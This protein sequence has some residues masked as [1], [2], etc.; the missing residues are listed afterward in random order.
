MASLTLETVTKTFGATRAVDGVSLEVAAGEFVALLGPS[1][2]GKSTLLRLLAGFERA[3]AGVIRLGGRTM[4]GG[5]IHV[6][7]ERRSLGMVFQSYALWPHMTVARNVGYALRVQKVPAAERR[8]RVAAALETV[9][10]ANLAERRP[11]ALSGGQRQRVALARCLVK[12]PAIMLLDEPLANLDVHLRESMQTEFRR[13]HRETGATMVYVTHDQAEAMALAD[14]VAVMNAGVVH[15]VDTPRTL[16]E[17][18]ADAMVA[19][20]VGKGTVLSGEVLAVGWPDGPSTPCRVRLWGTEI[21]AR[22]APGT[23]PGPARICVRPDDLRLDAALPE[24]STAPPPGVLPVRVVMGLYQGA[25]TLVTVA[26]E[27]APGMTL[28]LRQPGADAPSEGARIGL[29]VRA[30]WVVPDAGAR[31]HDPTNHQD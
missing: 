22:A 18:P 14:R 21:E 12:A 27:A 23:R 20:F 15:Q 25:T 2:C 24:G 3:D 19:G 30:A 11:A 5:G 10:L 17:R 1:G 31:D 6:P 8:R 13:V 16:F 9:G 26:P 29:R 7:P 4:D 28:T